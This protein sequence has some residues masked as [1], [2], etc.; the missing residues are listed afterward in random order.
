LGWPDAVDGGE[1]VVSDQ[2]VLGLVLVNRS[3][4]PLDEQAER[5]AV[6]RDD[7]LDRSHALNPG[8]DSVRPS[9]DEIRPAD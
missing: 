6:Q 5:G 8:T 1:L 2:A 4:A 9:L 7:P 3:T